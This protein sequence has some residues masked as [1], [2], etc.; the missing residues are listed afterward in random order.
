MWW[1]PKVRLE[2]PLSPSTGPLKLVSIVGGG[3]LGLELEMGLVF[4]QAAREGGFPRG[5][6]S[7]VTQ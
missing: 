4:H 7:L 3:S 1:T 5:V 2:G 6:L